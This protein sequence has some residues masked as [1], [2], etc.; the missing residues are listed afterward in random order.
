MND[1]FFPPEESWGTSERESTCAPYFFPILGWRRKLGTSGLTRVALRRM[2]G[3]VHP[4]A[5]P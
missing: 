4:I 5:T 2:D 3:E 1:N